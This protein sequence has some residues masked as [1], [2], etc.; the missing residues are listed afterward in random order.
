[1]AFSQAQH[2]EYNKRDFS[3]AEKTHLVYAKLKW[4]RVGW[5][6]LLCWVCTQM[7][8]EPR[9]SVKNMSISYILE[10]WCTCPPELA[11]KSTAAPSWPVN[12][13]VLFLSAV[14]YGLEK[15]CGLL[16]NERFQCITRA[17]SQQK[18]EDTAALQDWSLKSLA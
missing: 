12:T 8:Q 9:L 3:V 4:G 14:N 11:E 1:M 18:P 15:V 2:H 17:E 5:L 7:I 6:N 13:V 16:A 10:T